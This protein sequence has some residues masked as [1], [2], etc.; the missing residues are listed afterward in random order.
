MSKPFDVVLKTLVEAGPQSWPAVVGLPTGPVTGPYADVSAISGAAD[1]VL[2][3]DAEPRYL[4]HLDFYAGH[5]TAYAPKKLRWY[6]AVLDARH[7]LLVHSVVVVLRPESDSPQLTGELVRRFPERPPHVVFRY[8][9]VRV[10]QTPVETFL[11][12]SLG[13]LPL[14]P[15]SAVSQAELPGVIEQMKQRLSGRKARALAGELWAST[16]VL[17]G[18]K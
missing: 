10:W 2:R 12:G 13:L 8:D 11:G 17:L 15:V 16:F 18:L 5:D 4:L 14:A 7:G 6:N 3:V 1:K 9:V